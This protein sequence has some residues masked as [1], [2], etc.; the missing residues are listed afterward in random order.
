MRRTHSGRC[1][2][3]VVRYVRAAVGVEARELADVVAGDGH[4]LVVLRRQQLDQRPGVERR[5]WWDRVSQ[6]PPPASSTTHTSQGHV[7]ERLEVVGLERLDVLP[8]ELLRV[9][10][11]P[12]QLAGVHLRHV[13]LERAVRAGAGGGG[14]G[15][16]RVRTIRWWGCGESP[17]TFR[18]STH[19]PPPH[20][21][22]RAPLLPELARVLLQRVV[23]V[24]QIRLQLLVRPVLVFLSSI[25]RWREGRH[26]Q[27]SPKRRSIT[28]P[29]AR[30]LAHH[31]RSSR[32]SSVLGSPQEIIS[33]LSVSRRP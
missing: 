4:H 21:H 5:G 26:G 16:R 7:L 13:P 10:D 30:R 3:H 29:N 14:G 15:G 6:T 12:P 1:A 19:T 24:V 23:Q 9:H 18:T 11:A 20:H 8:P 2:L 25:M 27:T 28:S 32:F 17:G 31:L 22:A 33:A